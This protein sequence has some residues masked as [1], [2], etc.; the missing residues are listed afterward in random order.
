VNQVFAE[1]VRAGIF[2]PVARPVRSPKSSAQVV[3]P[4]AVAPSRAIQYGVVE[5]SICRIILV[6]L[7]C[8]FVGCGGRVTSDGECSTGSV[9]TSCFGP[10]GDASSTYTDGSASSLARPD[11]GATNASADARPSGREAD[12]GTR[13]AAVPEDGAEVSSR[14]AGIDI[15]TACL[16]DADIFI[17]AGDDGF[18]HRGPPTI[19]PATL[20]SGAGGLQQEEGSGSFVSVGTDAG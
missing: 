1:K 8:F 11:T 2:R 6:G 19:L 18:L 20:A 14:D 7:T 17:I 16:G 15:S 3:T 12:A 10:S 5:M 4:G 9:V 13:D